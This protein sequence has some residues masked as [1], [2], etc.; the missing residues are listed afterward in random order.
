MTDT[1]HMSSLLRLP[2]NS[3]H[4]GDRRLPFPHTKEIARGSLIIPLPSFFQALGDSYD[5]TAFDFQTGKINHALLQSVMQKAAQVQAQAAAA[6]QAAKLAAAAQQVQA[7]R[8]TYQQQQ[9]QQRTSGKTQS[10]SNHRSSPVVNG[11]SRAHAVPAKPAA[12]PVPPAP[13][14][15]QSLVPP[16]RQTASIF[17][18]PVTVEKRSLVSCEPFACCLK[19]LD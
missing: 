11:T 18:Q 1:K 17:K 6:Q 13:T 15:D 14:P 9:Q 19:G 2:L 10:S 7:S 12:P 5:L 3:A 16:I 4:E 8:S